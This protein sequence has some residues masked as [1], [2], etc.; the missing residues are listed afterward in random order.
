MPFGSLS[1]TPFERLARRRIAYSA[2]GN[3]G[4]LLSVV[5]DLDLALLITAR[6]YSDFR[7]WRKS[8]DELVPQF[9]LPAAR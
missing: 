2:E 9:I 7:V 1:R 6:N 5:P 8:R 4:Q 3:G